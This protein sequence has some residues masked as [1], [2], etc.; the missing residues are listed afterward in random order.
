MRRFVTVVAVTLAALAA[1]AFAEDFSRSIPVTQTDRQDPTAA[2]ALYQRVS[3]VAK[4]L[5]VK[6]NPA[7]YGYESVALRAR[8][9]CEREAIDEAIVHAALPALAAVHA[10]AMAQKAPSER[11]TNVAAR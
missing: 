2:A 8:I 4:S 6:A 5:C 1:P 11:A 7:I 10:Q 9:A 3:L